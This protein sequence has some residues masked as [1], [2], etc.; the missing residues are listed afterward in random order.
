MYRVRCILRE[1]PKVSSWNLNSS[2]KFVNIYF[3]LYFNTAGRQ[4]GCDLSYLVQKN[5]AAVRQA[6]KNYVSVWVV[7]Q[8]DHRL[9]GSGWYFNT[10]GRLN[11]GAVRRMRYK[12]FK[13]IHHTH[14]FPCIPGSYF[15]QSMVLY[16][17]SMVWPYTGVRVM[18]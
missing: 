17:I 8:Y 3:G 9:W 15:D 16:L 4:G 1:N 13:K 2:F 6:T 18:F 5:S 7:F 14:K 10:T 11:G 12:I